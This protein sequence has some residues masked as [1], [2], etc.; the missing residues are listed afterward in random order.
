M[1]HL[2]SSVQYFLYSEAVDMRKGHYS[3][4]GI[5]STC[6]QQNVLNGSVFVF[7]NKRSNKIKL[8]QWD[9]DGFAV[10]EKHLEQGTFER[11]ALNGEQSIALTSLQLQ[12]ILEG[13]VLKSVKHKFRYN[14]PQTN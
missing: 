14:H 12:H 13:V 3:L 2:S 11:I 8:L 10:Y 5:V 9:Q 7:I 4:S 6:M 1:L